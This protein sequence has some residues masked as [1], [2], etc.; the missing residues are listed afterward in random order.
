MGPY[1]RLLD[2]HEI[3]RGE[4]RR[5]VGGMWD[6]IG[7]LQ[8]D[9]L[10]MH[11]L[12]PGM[13]VLDVGC[14][15]LRAGVHLVGFLEPGRYYGV[16]RNASL[17]DAGY[18]VELAAVRLQDKLPREHLLADA[19]FDVARFGVSFD[20]ALAHSLFTHLPIEEVRRCFSA[21]ACV[22]RPGGRLFATFYECPAGAAADRPI[23]HEP[24][25]IVTFP[26]RNPYH[27]RPAELAG[28]A[29]ELGLTLRGW[30]EWGHPRAQRM[31]CFERSSA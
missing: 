12:Q 10:V 29:D 17:L 6:A 28:C 27:Y 30:G 22:L 13:R 7:R 5:M 9:H 1:A 24:G 31:M 15:A 2:D 11:G 23:T 4:H 3:R 26:D 25:A 14:G 21:V 20:I 16:D 19:A 8:L 18:D